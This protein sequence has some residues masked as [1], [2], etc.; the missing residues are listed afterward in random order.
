MGSSLNSPE[1][2]EMASRGFSTPR[3]P[4][5][6]W[7]PA[8]CSSCSSVAALPPPVPAAL[9]DAAPP[10]SSSWQLEEGSTPGGAPSAI[11]VLWRMFRGPSG[12][13]PWDRPTRP[14]GLEEEDLCPCPALSTPDSSSPLW[15]SGGAGWVLSDWCTRACG[16]SSTPLG[17]LLRPTSRR[18]TS[19]A[20]SSFFS[21]T[22]R[23]A[24]CWA[25]KVRPPPG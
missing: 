14:I 1:L 5:P 2:L 4:F 7:S 12:V 22:S 23:G 11:L 8:P 3:R 18:G 24:F 16:T 9:L 19:G 21:T 6:I 20:L 25:A 13:E 17:S 15:C 10:L